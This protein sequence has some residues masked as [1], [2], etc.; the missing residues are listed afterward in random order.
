MKN[1]LT[2]AFMSMLTLVLVWCGGNAKPKWAA[3]QVCNKT[4][5]F[6][7]ELA[8]T[9]KEQQ[10]WLMYR[11]EMADDAG[12]LFVF[13]NPTWTEF[14][15]KNTKIPLDM[16]RISEAGEVLYIKEYAAPCSE[17]DSANN[18]CQLF[19]PE[20][21]VLA[22]YVLEVNANKTREAGIY[23]WITV[24]IYNVDE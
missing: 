19:G 20:K 6:T 12:M 8:D 18:T 22:K 11:E 23:E 5:C 4:Q 9:P 3:P 14:W 10:E 2:I 7:V 21:W 13:D 16:I 24:D 15:M 1:F 17:E